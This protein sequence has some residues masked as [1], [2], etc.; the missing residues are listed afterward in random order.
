MNENNP[1]VDHVSHKLQFQSTED[2]QLIERMAREIWPTCYGRILTQGQIDY[3]LERMYS[4]AALLNA[5]ANGQNFFLLQRDRKAIGFWS[6]QLDYPQ[7]GV[8]KLHK[9]YLKEEFQGL[10]FGKWVIEKVLEQSRTARMNFLELN[11]NRMNPAVYFYEKLGFISVSEVDIPIGNG[12]Y[13]NDFVM[14]I[15]I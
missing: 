4:E 12:F 2:W 15:T 5:H 11:V 13:M 1:R 14:R 10:G 9:L 6:I 3:M 8:V 7:K